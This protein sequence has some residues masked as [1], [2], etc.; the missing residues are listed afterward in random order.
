M[1]QRSA[2]VWNESFCF[3]HV[4]KKQEVGGGWWEEQ[5]DARIVRPMSV[6]SGGWQELSVSSGRCPYRPADAPTFRR[7]PRLSPGSSSSW[8]WGAHDINYAN[9]MPQKKLQ[10]RGFLSSA[11]TSSTA[12][13]RTT[14]RA[15]CKKKHDQKTK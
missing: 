5:V 3:P 2:T 8:F 15:C 9:W 13:H 12:S 10:K 14:P 7:L 11:F 4:G 1:W 6:S